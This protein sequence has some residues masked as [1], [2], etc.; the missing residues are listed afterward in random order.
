[1]KIK[2]NT[3][4]ACLLVLSLNLTSAQEVPQNWQLPN[5]T[6]LRLDSLNPDKKAIYIGLGYHNGN[7]EDSLVY[8]LDGKDEPFWM[9]GPYLNKKKKELNTTIE[10]NLVHVLLVDQ[11]VP[12]GNVSALLDEL[13]YL[14]AFNVFW[15][16]ENGKGIFVRMP[17]FAPDLKSYYATKRSAL[18][19]KGNAAVESDNDPDFAPPTV[20]M[21]SPPPSP[22]NSKTPPSEKT[23]L[24]VLKGD[25]VFFNNEKIM[26]NALK[27]KC[28]ST[29][30]KYK[31]STVLIYQPIPTVSFQSYISSYA[32]ILG[33]YQSVWEKASDSM[34]HKVFQDLSKGEQSRVKGTYP[35]VILQFRPLQLEWEEK[36]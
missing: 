30:E 23:P 10:R 14:G 36:Q 22:M 7:P 26:L 19:P 2:T 20:Q 35:F 24:I 9:I 31:A 3:L 4:I 12:F 17:A 15:Q 11:R 16:V 13:N 8:N 27:D 32:A 33:A 25:E 18:I 21:A 5:I 28:V 6:N 1:M 29:I 34:F